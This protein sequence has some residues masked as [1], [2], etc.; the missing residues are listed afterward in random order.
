M[1]VKNAIGDLS[2]A[3]KKYPSNA[4]L[5]RTPEELFYSKSEAG[6]PTVAPKERRLV[7]RAGFEPATYGLGIR[8]SVQLSYRSEN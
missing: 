5:L 3:H 8:C 1:S 6:L 4:R 7:P 2:P